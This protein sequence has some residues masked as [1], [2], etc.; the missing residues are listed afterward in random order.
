[1]FTDTPASVDCVEC[2]F[3]RDVLADDVDT[4]GQVT[5]RHGQETGHTLQISKLDEERDPLTP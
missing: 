3:S 2:E 1:M 4:P 5:I